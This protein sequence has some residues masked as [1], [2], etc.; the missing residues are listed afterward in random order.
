MEHLLP[1]AIACVAALALVAW[2]HRR[3]RGA[4]RALARRHAAPEGLQ[5]PDFRLPWCWVGTRTPLYRDCFRAR[6]AAEGIRLSGIGPWAWS[7]TPL[8]LPWHAVRRCGVDGPLQLGQHDLLLE[9]DGTQVGLT[10]P[11]SALPALARHGII[12]N[13]D[14]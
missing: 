13:T 11:P 2:L 6:I 3:T 1:V 9:L 7:R 10:F 5:G 14:S 8:L 4:W 12:A